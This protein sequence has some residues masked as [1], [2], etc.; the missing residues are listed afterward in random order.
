M[1]CVLSLSQP[2]PSLD[3]VAEEGWQQSQQR[4]RQAPLQLSVGWWDPVLG[5]RTG[6]GGGGTLFQSLP[7]AVLALQHQSSSLQP[8]KCCCTGPSGDLYVLLV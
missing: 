6:E 5:C 3:D 4:C 7:W 2:S 1:L 8:P